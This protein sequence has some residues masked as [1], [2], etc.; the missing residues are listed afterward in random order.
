LRSFE[1]AVPILVR[2]DVWAN[3]RGFFEKVGVLLVERR[4]L[5]SER[6]RPGLL[7]VVVSGEVLLEWRSFSVVARAVELRVFEGLAFGGDRV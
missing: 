5:T 7:L 6:L 2:L 1:T 4:L 3:L